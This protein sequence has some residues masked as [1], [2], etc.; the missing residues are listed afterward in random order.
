[1]NKIINPAM[2]SAVDLGT[3]AYDPND[4]DDLWSRLLRCG[5]DAGLYAAL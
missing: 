4:V 1:M 3:P 5:N 2:S